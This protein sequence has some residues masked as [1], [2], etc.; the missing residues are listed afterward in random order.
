VAADSDDSIWLSNLRI[1]FHSGHVVAGVVGQKMPRY[2]LFGDTVNTAS[3]MKSNGLAQRIHVSEQA[4]HEL[5]KTSHFAIGY[6]GIVPLKNRGDMKCYWLEGFRRQ[7]DGVLFQAKVKSSTNENAP[8]KKAITKGRITIDSHPGF[9]DRN[10][11]GSAK[12][13]NFLK[14]QTSG[15][16]MGSRRRTT[17][18]VRFDD[19]DQS[20]DDIRQLRDEF[21]AQNEIENSHEDNIPNNS[22]NH[23]TEP[24]KNK[25]VD[26]TRIKDELRSPSQMTTESGYFSNPRSTNPSGKL[27]LLNNNTPQ[28]LN[29]PRNNSEHSKTYQIITAKDSP[30]L[31]TSVLSKPSQ[32]TGQPADKSSVLNNG[33]AMFGGHQRTSTRRSN[34]NFLAE[35]LSEDDNDLNETVL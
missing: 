12:G 21:E 5:K 33:R 29:E 27:S 26:E 6:R 14:A 20:F 17:N 23:F 25:P 9:L 11:F 22:S 35:N 13:S 24:P 1:G 8:V 3:R 18:S 34:S 16:G 31:S 32:R 30:R 15:V 10:S 28:T 7:D 4:Y 2:C 19:I